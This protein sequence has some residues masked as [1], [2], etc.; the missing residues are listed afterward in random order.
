[1]GGA[2]GLSVIHAFN[3]AHACAPPQ[4]EHLTENESW[5]INSKLSSSLS[6]PVETDLPV[7]GHTIMTIPT[8]DLLH[9]HAGAG[10][11]WSKRP[12]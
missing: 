10:I 8:P 11:A 12:E 5:G 2:G 1:M 3:K 4:A 6:M 9:R 7:T